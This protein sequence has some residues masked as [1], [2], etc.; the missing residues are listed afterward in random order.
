MNSM[1]SLKMFT[2]LSVASNLCLL[3]TH[4]KSFDISNIDITLY[5]P[6]HKRLVIVVTP[7]YK[8]SMQMASMTNLMQTLREVPPPIH[9][10]VIE[11]SEEK[12]V[13]IKR[14]LARS[15]LMHTHLAIVSPE[16]NPKIWD[17]KGARQRSYAL[18]HIR[19]R[20]ADQP[21]ALIYFADDDN[22]YDVRLF[23]LI[24]QVSQFSG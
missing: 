22:I 23:D 7:T 21:D 6:P 15:G 16:R 3:A 24:R 8:R 4:L 5:K 11:D 2:A 12:S 14:L 13:R 1:L 18:Q 17:T 10:V 20:Y 9:W 19:H